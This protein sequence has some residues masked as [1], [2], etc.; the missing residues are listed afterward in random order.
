MQ[1]AN[2][3][4]KNTDINWIHLLPLVFIIAIIPLIVRLK[5]IP[6]TGD[7]Y[8]FWTGLKSNPDVFSYYKAIWLLITVT[9]AAVTY[10]F[11]I[12][13]GDFKLFKKDLLLLYSIALVYV[14]FVVASTLLSRYPSIAQWGYPDRYEGA[15]MLVAY[16]V[17][18]FLTSTL[19][20][21]ESEVKVL[22]W[23][24]MLGSMVIGIIGLFQ[25]FG[26][27]IW[28]SEFG[29]KLIIPNEYNSIIKAVETTFEK[30]SI[31][32]T[33]YH[34]DYVGSYMA[35]L[36]PFSISLLILAKAKKVKFY[37]G[38]MA[39][40]MGINWIGSNSRAGLIGGFLA[41]IIFVVF[42]NKVIIKNLKIFIAA[43][44]VL[45]L[46]VIGLNQIS[47]GY[48]Y[49]RAESLM[50]DIKLLMVSNSED[51]PDKA[52]LLKN[53][54]INGN[55]A[56]ISTVSE[57]LSIVV[58]D[59]EIKFSGR[60]NKI[61]PYR[62]DKEKAQ[63]MLEDQAYKDYHIL[64]GKLDNKNILKLEKG[65][66]K[67]T[68]ELN[69][70]QIQ[71]IDNKGRVVDL[72][73]TKSWG[74]E[75]KERIGSSRGYIWS[76]SIPLLKDTII[77]GNGPDTFAAVFPQ[78]DIM[79]KYFAYYGDMWQIVDKPHNLYLQIALNTGVMSLL[80]FLVMIGLYIRSSFKMYFSKE[81]STFLMSIGLS[82]FVAVMG[83]LGAAFFND[84]V[85]SVAPV[86]WTL[87]GVGISIN[88]MIDKT[89][90]VKKA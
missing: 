68:F 70:N 67:L 78:N 18:F 73:P 90:K 44:L 82:I 55:K 29:K 15:Y 88:H 77:F 86:F 64:L 54:S 66:I 72:Q 16:I 76:R 13:Q 38:F 65:S 23:A 63:L 84:S 35:M 48:V 26:Y 79:G 53:I 49:K 24:L 43:L 85:V 20:N 37:M 1:G 28:T 17:I 89:S 40:L 8:F 61:I 12:F 59:E 58:K 75:G 27:D 14:I 5:V 34:R 6:L 32:S 33:L 9:I 71:L 46:F 4:I 10:I 25:Y 80:G 21:N 52:M 19:V 30:N 57:E 83:Y 36:F 62:Y 50:S 51:K 2:K 7:S 22:T 56:T 81:N 47:N 60:D 41:L 11:R 87:F 3:K 31:Y 69:Q 74:F 42:A 45:I 39:A